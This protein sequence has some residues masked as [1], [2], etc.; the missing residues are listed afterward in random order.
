M[1]VELLVN[2]SPTIVLVPENDLDIHMLKLFSN[3]EIQ[4]TEI[5]NATKILD[6]QVDKGLIIRTVKARI[7]DDVREA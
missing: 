1:K 7:T 3:Q 2:G 6:K 5:I 4:A